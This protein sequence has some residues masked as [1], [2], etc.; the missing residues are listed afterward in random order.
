[1]QGLIYGV[2]GVGFLLLGGVGAGVLA[3]RD[4]IGR[5]FW[6]MALAMNLPDLVDAIEFLIVNDSVTGAILPVDCGQHLFGRV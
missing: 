3:A 5:W 1:M 4:G 6:P 2:G